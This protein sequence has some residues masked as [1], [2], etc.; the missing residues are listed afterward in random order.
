M[1]KLI[2][3]ALLFGTIGVKA[4]TYS[5]DLAA[6][7]SVLEKTPSYKAQIKGDRSTA[8]KALFDSLAAIGTENTTDFQ[9]FYR[10]SQLF[11]PLRDNHLAFY[12]VADLA[13][14]RTKADIEKFVQSKSFA[15]FPKYAINIDS[16]KAALSQKPAESIEGIYHYDKYYTVGLFKSNE[17]EYTGVVLNSDVNLWVPGQIAIHLYEY[18]PGLY[19]AIYSHPL[20]RN[21]IY[22]GIEKYSNQSLVNSYFYNSYSSK[23]YTKQLL[24]VDH[25]NLPRGSSRFEFRNLSDDVQ[26]LLIR[27]FQNN[28]FTSK[29]SANFYDSIKNLVTASNLIVDLRNNEGGAEGQSRKYYELIRKF[30]ARGK[31]YILVNNGTLSQAEILTLQLKKLANT[32][33]VGQTTKGMLAYGSNYGKRQLLPSQKFEVYITDMAGRSELLTYEDYGIKPDSYLHD[34]AD[35]IGQ[36]LELIRK[37]KG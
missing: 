1:R 8:Y 27:S 37:E 17:R 13:N 36:V 16:L 30:S 5:D 35:W 7:R 2:L 11:F 21:F 29:Q 10:L 24:S 9:H 25:V 19:K 26:Y 12:Q 14:F 23:T 33:T 28:S 18:E 15:D 6:L 31:V 34:D 22:Q 4:Q 20:T 3:L 32:I